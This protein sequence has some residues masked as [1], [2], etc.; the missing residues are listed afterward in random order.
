MKH[1]QSLIGTRRA[2]GL[3]ILAVVALAIAITSWSRPLA[4]PVHRR[5]RIEASRFAYDP[6]VVRVN[7]NDQVTLELVATDV[8]HGLYIEGYNFSLMADPGQTTRISFI[9]DR[10]GT[11]R[12]RCLVLC[13]PLHPFMTGKLVVAPDTLTW[14]AIAF[15][16]PAALVGLLRGR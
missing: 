13:G 6:A 11:F 16:I 15:A 14:W 12:L 8:V 5:I 2:G 1:L 4:V 9:A 10:S 7:R 3:A